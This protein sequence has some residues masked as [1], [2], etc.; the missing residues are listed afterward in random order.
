MKKAE[1]SH[2]YAQNLTQKGRTKAPTAVQT[3]IKKR[4]ALGVEGGVKKE[5]KKMN[6]KSTTLMLKEETERPK[7]QDHGRGKE[8]GSSSPVSG[9]NEKENRCRPWP[10]SDSESKQV[11]ENARTNAN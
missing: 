7:G 3:S 11:S 8:T 10:A 1:K 4:K 6:E 2:R 9:T 5:G